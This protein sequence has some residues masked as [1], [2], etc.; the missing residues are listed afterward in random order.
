[1]KAVF[2]N[3]FIKALFFVCIILQVVMWPT[4]F[5]VTFASILALEGLLTY[6]LTSRKELFDLVVGGGVLLF[7]GGDGKDKSV[8]RYVTMVFI[9]IYMSCFFARFINHEIDMQPRMTNWIHPSRIRNFSYGDGY[10]NPLPDLDV[11]DD[12]SQRMRKNSFVWPKVHITDATLINGTLFEGKPLSSDS[13]LPL[14]CSNDDVKTNFSCYSAN[15]VPFDVPQDDF[16]YGRKR[17]FVP[18]S[19]Q[20]Y[21]VDVKVTPRRAIVKCA[22][23][24]VYR[25][26]V[27]GDGGVV[28]PLD[29]PASALPGSSGNN[30]AAPTSHQHCGLFG[31][32]S[33]CL[34]YR[35]SFSKEAYKARIAEK[36]MESDNSLIFRLPI[37]TL[38]IDPNT[39]RTDLDA[40]IVSKYADVELKFSWHYNTE[41]I[42]PIVRT[43]E[44]WVRADDDQAQEWRDSS[45]YADVFFKF[46][47]AITPLLI[48]WYVLA[49]EFFHIISDTNQVLFLCIFVLLPSVLIF[50]S[51]GAWLPMAGCIVCAIAINHSPT[52]FAS[53][54]QK[55]PWYYKH[56]RPILFFFTAVCN[57]IQFA[58]VITLI[59][60]AGWPA[61]YYDYSIKQ[62]SDLSSKF[63]ISETASPTWIALMVPVS[64]I[65]NASYLIG[66]AMCIV[67]E[68]MPHMKMTSS[69]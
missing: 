11:T 65:V 28:Y 68:S 67:L 1:M 9:G 22:D 26:V 53:N 4:V 20:F 49:K 39:G 16:Y 54:V 29:Y 30:V 63:I 12:E 34:R 6:F 35:H 66:A 15:L 2:F 51:V 14:T 59:A 25:L 19:S 48:V 13:I 57:S 37:R 33:W 7:H 8:R 47:I 21:V 23:L 3:I 17:M 44:Q 60:Q 41:Q 31:E 43:I 52:I 55:L 62:M 32:D 45:A 10:N 50:L 42:P 64:L 56:W 58:W 46:A 61:F 69:S 36:C 5:T 18:M 38:D 27:N 24:E 40:L